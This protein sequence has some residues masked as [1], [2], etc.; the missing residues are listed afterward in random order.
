MNGADDKV[1]CFDRSLNLRLN[2]AI[3]CLWIAPLSA[4]HDFLS[5]LYLAPDRKGFVLWMRTRR[6]HPP[7]YTAEWYRV[8]IEHNNAADVIAEHDSVIADLQCPHVRGTVYK[9]V[10][11]EH[12]LEE[13]IDCVT[14]LPCMQT[15]MIKP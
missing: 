14:Q 5:L 7:P 9:V 11:G 3:E 2:E 6:Y 12:S 1:Y 10:R 8:E 15:I 13:F 4:G